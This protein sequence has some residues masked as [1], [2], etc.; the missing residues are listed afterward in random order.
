MQLTVKLRN[1]GSN[2]ES[3]NFLA[4]TCMEVHSLIIVNEN[5]FSFHW[6]FFCS[7]VLYAT[8]HSLHIRQVHLLVRTYLHMLKACNFKSGVLAAAGFLKLFS[9]YAC[10]C[11]HVHACVF[12]CMCVCVCVRVCVHVCVCVCVHVCVCGGHPRQWKTTEV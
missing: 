2:P 3:K 7:H 12:V 1:Q 11:V 8:H 10:A 4:S 6:H 5:L 9:V